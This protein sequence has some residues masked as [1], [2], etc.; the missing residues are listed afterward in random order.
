MNATAAAGS[1]TICKVKIALDETQHNQLVQCQRLCCRLSLR[2]KYA[3]NVCTYFCCLRHQELA[4]QEVQ[5]IRPQWD[6]EDAKAARAI[7]ARC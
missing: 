7:N 1:A 2:S 5:S 6:V 3:Y 4:S